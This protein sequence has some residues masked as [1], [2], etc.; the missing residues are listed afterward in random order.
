[1]SR[2]NVRQLPP[3]PL[4]AAFDTLCTEQGVFRE[5][6]LVRFLKEERSSGHIDTKIAMSGLL[7]VL[8]QKRDV[9]A[10][11]LASESGYPSIKRFAA[12]SAS[13]FE[14]AL[15]LKKNGYLTHATAVFLHGLTD[16]VPQTIYVN[17]EQSAK[18][19]PD[20]PL[21]QDSLDRAFRAHQRASRY[22]FV[23]ERN[24]FVILSGKHTGQYGVISLS[25]GEE[26]LRTT[27][28]ER[29]LID[30]TVRPTYGGG[31][32]QVRAAFAAALDRVSIPKL[33]TTL[34]ALDYVY[35]YHQALGFY[36]S[37]VGAPPKHLDRLRSLGLHLD[38]YLA[39]GLKKPAYDPSWRI[40][41]PQGL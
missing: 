2:S 31:V 41:Y 8:A 15:S 24:R 38:F 13:P 4:L 25:R 29:T 16:Q 1:M 11:T 37:R 6:E 34:G 36:L 23:H 17:A 14:I 40:Y 3:D 18:P 9:Q 30:I 12:P 7:E 10:L 39:H 19:K 33:V 21:T 5:A 32:H 28:L 26:K 27:D 35:P 20:A 22:V